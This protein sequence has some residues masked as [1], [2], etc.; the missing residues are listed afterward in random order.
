MGVGA[1][2][3]GRR[4]EL[5]GGPRRQTSSGGPERPPCSAA[6]SHW[7]GF[8]GPQ[9]I[10]PEVVFFLGWDPRHSEARATAGC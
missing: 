10:V 2:G 6:A 5:G 8:Q 1:K 9:P 4:R 3:G 7:L